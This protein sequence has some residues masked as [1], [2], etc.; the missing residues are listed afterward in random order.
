MVVAVW[1]VV[2]VV[3]RFR[4]RR[5]GAGARRWF[6]VTVGFCGAFESFC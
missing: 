6:W 5:L 1:D 4:G 3:V 2:L